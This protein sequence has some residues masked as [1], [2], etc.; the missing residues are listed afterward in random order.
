[1][2]FSFILKVFWKRGIGLNSNKLFKK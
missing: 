1:M 2:Q